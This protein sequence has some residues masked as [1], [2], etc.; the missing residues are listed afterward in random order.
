MDTQKKNIDDVMEEYNRLHNIPIDV[1]DSITHSDF[2][3]GVQNRAVGFIVMSGEPITLVKGGRKMMF[4]VFV[5]LYLIAP[6]IFI[7]FWAYHERNWW[8]LLGIIVASLI[9]PQLAQRKGHS[10]GGVFLVLCFVCW[11]SGG[12]HNYYTFL[13]LC[14][15]WGYMF[16]KI[17][18]SAQT[19]YAM[20]SLVES[21]VLFTKAIAEKRIRIE[22]RRD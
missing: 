21:P 11:I 18:E 17:A 8:L 10:I 9:A 7:P 3:T 5:M 22:R 2:V 6:V 1:T 13:F 19:G 4:N 16:F 15:L 12:I 14:A 20:Q